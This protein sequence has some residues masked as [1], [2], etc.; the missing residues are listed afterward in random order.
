M[1]TANQCLGGEDIFA[2]VKENSPTGEFIANFSIV[3]DPGANTIRLCLTGE[4]A[5]WFFL[6]GRTIR[7]NTSFSRTLDREVQGSVLIAALTCYEDETIQSEHR[8]MVEILNENDNKPIFLKTNIQT[9]DISELTSVNTVAFTVQARDADDDTIMYIMD[10]SLPDAI[11]FRIDLPNSGKVILAK[12]LD[13]ET[14]TQLQLIIYA[15]E[16]NT[17]EKYNTTTEVTVNVLDGDDQY[18]QFQPCTLLSQDGEPPICTNPVYMVNITE[19]E[20]DTILYFSPGPIHAVDG[21]K[22]LKTPL[23]YSI[24]SG[25]DNGRFHIDN[26]TGEI[27]LTRPVENRLLTPMIR[28]RIMA[29]QIDDPKKYTVATALI[30]VLA[31]NRFPPQFN[32]TLYK[33]FIVENDSPATLVST[34]GNAVLVLQ[35][36]DLDFNDGMNPKIHYSLRQ[37]PNET[38]LFHV[39]QQGLLIAKTNQLRAFEKHF[40]EVLA[41]DQESGD[42]AN[43]TVD[44]EVL[45]KGQEVPH[46]PFGEERLY[47]LDMDMNTVG[48][49]AGIVLVLL[50]LTSL[51]LLQLAKWRRQQQNT[52]DRASVAQAR[53]PN[54]ASPGRPMPLIE[55]ISY[56]NEAFSDFDVSTSS[57]YGK[58]GLYTK[59]EDKLLEAE[60]N[61]DYDVSQ[62]PNIMT[63]VFTISEPSVRMASPLAYKGRAHDKPITKSVSFTEG[64]M[65]RARDAGEVQH[66]EDEPVDS[67][68]SEEMQ[69][70]AESMSLKTSRLLQPLQA[71]AFCEPSLATARVAEHR[72]VHDKLYRTK[73]TGINVPSASRPQEHSDSDDDDDD[74]YYNNDADDDDYA[75]EE[76]VEEIENPY[77]SLPL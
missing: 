46:S 57:L 72:H 49:I 71:A 16:M 60:H 6:E 61:R 47:S 38:K 28:L 66:A 42:T 30:R 27:M 62:L 1:H 18:P 32:R 4:D 54:V 75:N 41:T 34:Y 43:A 17:K 7:L 55:E 45:Q 59:K 37:K 48:G 35:A 67:R 23:L 73:P 76:E 74:D 13:Y 9:F 64:V 65:L 50:L 29:Y 69:L 70:R 22:G 14:K 25:A 36:I 24:L 5:D 12:P 21:D 2:K 33:G 3:G 58:Q 63:P 26:E 11:Y 8:I 40:V 20:K 77:K 19:M 44:I 31:K 53:H 52:A 15:V 39:T 10:K 56:H 51:V 68:T